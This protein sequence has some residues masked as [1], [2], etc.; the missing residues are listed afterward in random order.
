LSQR[1]LIRPIA[2]VAVVGL[3][4][5]VASCATAAK[6]SGSPSG[7]ATKAPAATQP[8]AKANTPLT[9]PEF[10]A[11]D[12]AIA[13]AEAAG[14]ATY[15]ADLLGQAK[16]ALADAH[17]KADADPAT[18]RG[19]LQTSIDKAHAARDAAWAAQRKSL[20]A[21]AQA[22]MDEA[23][24][25]GAEQA[26][27]E[28]LHD[29]Q[30][31][32]ADARAT[33]PQDF[34][35]AQTLYTTAV[36]K[37]HA[38]S[39]AALK[40][41][42]QKA[43]AAIADAEGVEAEKYAPAPLNEAR[44]ALDQARG[45]AGAPRDAAALYQTS[46]DKAHAARDAA[47]T[48]RTQALLGQVDAALAQWKAL[49]PDQWDSD[50]D[51]ALRAQGETAEAAVR[52]DYG[53]G[54]PKATAAIA[55]LQD[56]TAKLSARLTAVQ[57]LKDQA[58]SALDAA[59]AADAP[60]WVPELVQSADDAFFQGTGA[61]K[62]FRLDAAEE[63]WNTALFQAKSAAAKAES[64]KARRQTEQLML[65]TMKKLE[66]ASGKTV[67][68]PQDHIIAPQPWDGE[69]EL[70][71]LQT[72]P[73]SVVIPADGSV[74]V[75]GDVQR[76]TYLDQAK[77]QW[78]QGVKALNAGDLTLA[79]ESFLQSQKLIDT[80][81]AMAVDKVYTVRLIPEHRDSL[82]RISAYGDIYSTPW[83]W[84]KIWKRNQKLIQNPDLIYPGWQLIIPPQ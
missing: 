9:A 37:A 11:A 53:T 19:L 69:K 32:T 72:K 1:K 84:P 64:E 17:A 16:Q 12:Q 36:T 67:V 70:K 15:S 6:P 24:A 39:D 5:V 8:E 23:I 31:A 63:A 81:L 33:G 14:A 18:A 21:Q 2:F 29:A 66:K 73:V 51:K 28:L 40:Q 77:D 7:E 4:W 35:G 57:A 10:Q 59:D 47:A 50:Q 52:A 78:V 49:Q 55:A 61:W 30:K 48:A 44:T 34:P 74:A 75:L 62:K 42:D 54:L 80:Y 25:V 20:D 60:V 38:A 58:Q 68:D 26:A 22:A 43:Q 46:I 71:Q 76:V 3:A 41:A 83:D 56:A 27:P 65:D 79:N 45:K 13:E 82:W